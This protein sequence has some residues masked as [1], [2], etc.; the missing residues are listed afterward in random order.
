M[1]VQNLKKPSLVYGLGVRSPF[2]THALAS[3]ELHASPILAWLEARSLRSGLRFEEAILARMPLIERSINA[4]DSFTLTDAQHLTITDPSTITIR[5]EGAPLEDLLVSVLVLDVNADT[6][7]ILDSEP[8]ATSVQL[9]YA[10]VADGASL[11]FNDVHITRCDSFRRTSVVLGESSQ[12]HPN[13]AFFTYG[14]AKVDLKS[15]VTHIGRES[16][17]DMKMRGVLAGSSQVIVQG[18]VTI[19][20]SAF[21]AN[22]YQQEDLILASSS[23][24]ARPIPNLAIGNNEVKCSHGATVSSVDPEAL[25]YLR[26]RGIR[27]R[28]ARSL[29]L[30]SFIAPIL[31]LLPRETIDALRARIRGVLDESR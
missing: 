2:S 31:D 7:L 14:S 11:S 28:D 20:S 9:I 16:F 23:A 4:D 8:V 27:E 13:H 6:K 18:D 22:G 1:T 5:L 12:V 15:S 29:L 17:S 10:H 25:F 26:S 19:T 24:I 21:D 30:S 3:S